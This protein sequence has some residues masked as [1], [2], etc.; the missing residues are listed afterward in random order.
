MSAVNPEGALGQA[1]AADD[2]LAAAHGNSGEGGERARVNILVVDDLPEKHLVFR[3]ILEEL[4]QN[5][6][7]A[8]S[9]REALRCVLEE[10]FA[11]IL[12]DVNMPDMDGFETASLIR[13]YKKTAQTP[14]VFV[15]AYVDEVQAVRGYALGAVDYIS[16]PVV[17]EILRSKVKVFV[18]LNLLTRELRQQVLAREAL[19]RAEAARSAA[20]AATRRADL[21]A[22]ASQVLSRSLDMDATL[23]GLLGFAAP[24]LADCAL[25]ALQDERGQLARVKLARDCGG[26]PP[27]SG[28]VVGEIEPIDLGDTVVRA[29]ALRET[30]RLPGPLCFQGLPADC[31]VLE[32]VYEAVVFPM[33]VG[34]RA[35]GALVLGLCSPR[36]LEAAEMALAKEVVSRAVIA[37]ENATLY[38]AIQ[39][40]DRRKNE[41][42]AMLAHELRNPLAPIRNAVH[43][44][45]RGGATE[46]NVTWSSEVIGRQVDHLA[47]LVD[48]LLDVSRI[49]R[50]KVMVNRDPLRLSEVIDHALETSRPMLEKR[51][52]HLVVQMP[53]EEVFFNG[54]LVRLAQVLSNLLNNAAK[55]T[56]TG[57]HITLD[58]TL[59]GSALR[60]SVKD[61]GMGIDPQLLPHVFDLF[62]QG[63][64]TLDRSEGGLGIG[65]TLVKHLVELHGG[66]VEAISGGR[67]CGAEFAFTLPEVT[68]A[69][70]TVEEAALRGV[71]APNGNFARVLVVD[72]VPASAES[73]SRLLEIEGHR[74]ATAGDGDAALAT[75]ASFRPDVIVLDIGLPGKS[76]FEVAAELR[77]SGAHA[78]TLLVAL[79]GYGGQEDRERGAR[80]GFSHYLVKPADIPTLLS[81]I[82]THAALRQISERSLAGYAPEGE[83]GRANTRGAA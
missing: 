6:V 76:G 68:V 34:E 19:A 50:G 55:F 52:H 9:G 44:L 53:R 74:V 24:G 12:L 1:S 17:P 41:F 3:S 7:S 21:L 14:I 33:Y 13:K 35:F 8:Y 22:E 36:S 61:N 54:D 16:S 29:L 59:N 81:I 26:A 51:R 65:L 58:A 70:S 37:L 47:T 56:P 83:A 28:V 82:S 42:L 63:D 69:A 45:Q 57:G 78:D 72:D 25:V 10:E 62:T 43:V 11:V 31:A 39:D 2:A 46:K 27:P 79:S 48:D 77:A 40:A 71:E 80:A 38:E 64:Q 32:P 18:D 67:D 20:E 60:I 75:A 15:T 66:R 30:L 73:L 49:A 23:A 5:I 4:G